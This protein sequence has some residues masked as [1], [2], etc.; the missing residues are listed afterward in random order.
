MEQSAEVDAA[1]QC[2][3]E[4]F[5]AGADE[6]EA[7]LAG[8][9][10]GAGGDIRLP[11]TDGGGGVALGQGGCGYGEILLTEPLLGQGFEQ[12]P[13]GAGALLAHRPAQR[14]PQ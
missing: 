6:A 9:G 3:V 12:E 13:F 4:G 7:V 14:L 11:K 10:A 1:L 5:P 2:E 8:G